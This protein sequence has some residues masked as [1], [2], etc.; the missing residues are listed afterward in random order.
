MSLERF[1]RKEVITA[2]PGE[3]VWTAA[4]KMT[5]AHVG[6]VVV[7]DDNRAP[8]G[9]LTDRDV[10]ARV[11]AGLR[12]PEDTPV[13][14]VMTAHV[15]SLP[16]TTPLDSALFAMR[17]YGVRRMPITDEKGRVCGLLSLDDLLVLL[18][19]ELGMTAEAVRANQGP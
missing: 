2:T 3:P 16:Q 1:C 12:D 5:Q 4:Q 8:I 6:A 17:E 15:E 11:V 14:D 9:I 10:A 7:V 19:A 13:G 18:S